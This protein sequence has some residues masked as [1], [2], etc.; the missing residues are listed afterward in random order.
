MMKQE[1]F[2]GRIKPSLQ[3]GV[4]FSIRNAAPYAAAPVQ[5]FFIEPCVAHCA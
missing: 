1:N 4:P 3:P 5:G 2:G